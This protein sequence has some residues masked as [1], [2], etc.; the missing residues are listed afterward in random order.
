MNNRNDN[1]RVSIQYGKGKVSADSSDLFGALLLFLGGLLGGVDIFRQFHNDSSKRDTENAS[2]KANAEAEAYEKKRQADADLYE[3]KCQADVEKEKQMHS[4]RHDNY[5]SDANMEES[6]EEV[7][8]K[9][10]SG[11]SW[12]ESFNS[13]FTMPPLP[14]VVDTIVGGSPEGYKPAMLL[15]LMSMFGALCFSKVRA[16]YVDGKNH[17]PNI[18]VIIEGGWGTGKGKF[19]D[20]YDALFKD[21]IESDCE[22]LNTRLEDR[23]EGLLPHYIIQTAGIG[24]SQAKFFEILADNQGVHSFVFE[25]E[26]LTASRSQA[27][28][29]GLHSDYL[30]KA[31][32]NGDVY[33]N[34]MSKDASKGKQAI[35]LNY[36]FTGTHNDTDK[37]ISKELEGGTASRIA[38]CVIPECGR[39]IPKLNL[40]DGTKLDEIR[41]QIEDWRSM[42]CYQDDGIFEEACDE[43]VIDLDYVSSKLVDWI[44]SQ[45]DLAEE[46][47]NHARKDIR[48]RAATIAFH[49]A[50]VLH[51]LW[52]NPSAKDRKA[53]ESVA[54]M[55]LYIANYCAERFLFKFGNDQNQMHKEARN[56][57]KV[58]GNFHRSSTETDTDSITDEDILS[59][60]GAS[61]GY[62][63]IAKRHGWKDPK[64]KPATEKA[65]RALKAYAKSKGCVDENGEGDIEKAKAVLSGQK[66]DQ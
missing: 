65:K 46:E 63:T 66:G 32:D 59:Y 14:P 53:R 8:D 60:D 33:Q 22:K 25:E 48:T 19:K 36:V 39:V 13:N 54:D 2:T 43:T 64:G 30:R 15:H 23:A 49:C 55:T 34:N 28:N 5:E 6:Q 38:W 37:F 12:L 10:Q 58:N 50:I 11:Q 52:G 26:I 42:Y 1:N 41:K 40:P 51:M 35:F 16:K 47:N 31:F 21:V 61:V 4:I 18:Q 62:G 24:V 44:D 57:E 20:V 9:E 3:R 7:L 29:N 45:Y 17:A 27:K 56:A